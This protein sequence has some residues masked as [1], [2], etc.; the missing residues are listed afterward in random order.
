MKNV[1]WTLII[2][3]LIYKVVEVFKNSSK[4]NQ[5][6]PQNNNSSIKQ[7]KS[8]AEKEMKDALQKHLNKDGEYVDFEEIK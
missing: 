1:I 8:P 2:V 4:I 6:N 7:P 5:N 3:W